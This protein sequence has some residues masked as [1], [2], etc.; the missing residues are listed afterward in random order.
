MLKKF[1]T[2]L[3]LGVAGGIVAA[4]LKWAGA[5]ATL[6][7]Y[8]YGFYG[9]VSVFARVHGEPEFATAQ[10]GILILASSAMALAIA[11][12]PNLS[13][14][15]IIVLGA[16]LVTFFLSP[17]LALFGW[18]LEPFSW[19]TGLVSSAAS[20]FAVF[21]VRAGQ[22]RGHSD[23][24]HAAPEKSPGMTSADADATGNPRPP[25]E[26]LVDDAAMQ[27]VSPEAAAT[28]PHAAAPGAS[29]VDRKA[30]DE[31]REATF[32]VCSVFPQ[33]DGAS[34]YAGAARAFLE[35]ARAFLLSAGAVETEAG[36]DFVRASFV[37][38]NP[39]DATAGGHAHSSRA[40]DATMMLTRHLDAFLESSDSEATRAL[41]FGLGVESA[42]WPALAPETAR[43]CREF[44][45]RLCDL[46]RR[47]GS[48]IIIGPRTQRFAGKA[49]EVRPLELT[50]DPV[51][52]IPVE[53]YQ[54]LGNAGC[55]DA[56]AAAERDAYWEGIVCLR[57]GNHGEA[58]ERF[59]RACAGG[60]PDPV[61]DYFT[62]V[63]HGRRPD[64]DRPIARGPARGMDGDDDDV[65]QPALIR[66]SDGVDTVEWITEREEEEEE[67]EEE[68]PFIPDR[69]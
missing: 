38:H 2:S 34:G 8:I 53:I 62:A 28:R 68:I 58:L 46:N 5:F 51:A 24:T 22:P 30:G 42:A 66:E 11:T 27:A 39:S 40:C 52:S 32:V 48:Q 44:A 31:K 25:A 60:R 43:E 37:S 33:E 18:K 67:E 19:L 17:V 23:D 12:I 49:I 7:D 57:S 61:L 20:A 21:P 59:A 3:G 47:Y 6:T 65:I 64:D 41:R 15:L 36:P 50:N 29:A 26:P 14:R 69:T 45:R 56:D 63:A 9:E 16:V 13:R 54:L 55:L 4:T 10:S 1:A 35:R